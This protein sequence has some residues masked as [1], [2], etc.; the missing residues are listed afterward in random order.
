MLLSCRFFIL[1]LVFFTT[2]SFSQSPN[3]FSEAKKI[4]AKIFVDHKQTLYCQCQYDSRKQV[5]LTSCGMQSAEDM[6]RAHRVEIEHIM[7]AENFGKQFEC[8]RT[9]LCV[10]NGQPYKGR[11]CCQKI[12]PKFRHIEAE[13]Y[14]L[15]PA[16][17]LVNQA[18]SNYRFGMLDEKQDFYGCAFSVNKQ[19]RRAEPPDFAKGVVAR[20]NLF[21][22][23]HY[24]V[25]ISDAQRKLLTAWNKLFPP[26]AWDTE[27]AKRV[28]VIEGYENPYIGNE[29]LTR[30][31]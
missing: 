26:D 23:D 13:L 8:W 11:R 7:A 30:I 17:G 29:H 28:A 14:N 9:P 21:I 3:S 4:V 31:F 6:K 5:S 1:L 19:L 25:R 18:R 16:V 27:W 24:G 20:A 10:K 15:W 2:S 22:A 12:D